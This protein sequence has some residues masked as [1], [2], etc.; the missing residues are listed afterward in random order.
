MDKRGTVSIP[1]TYCEE[2]AEPGTNPPVCAK[3]LEMRKRA[4]EGDEPTTVK[5]LEA[6]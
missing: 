4:G 5:E 1:C 6:K 3:H 2:D